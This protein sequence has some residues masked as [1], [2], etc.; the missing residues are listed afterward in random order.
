M[1][2]IFMYGESEAKSLG[3]GLPA[4]TEQSQDSDPSPP[5]TSIFSPC[6]QLALPLGSERW[7]RLFWRHKWATTPGPSPLEDRCPLE[8]YPTR[9]RGSGSEPGA[10]APCP[11]HAPGVFAICQPGPNTLP[12]LPA[13]QASTGKGWAG[14]QT[15]G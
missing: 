2:P 5:G 9:E 11:A 15:K 1:T 3:Q 10:L 7:R 6:S 12:P 4:S 14:R 8:V 13:R